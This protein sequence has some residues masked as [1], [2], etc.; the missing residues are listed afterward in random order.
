MILE[1]RT[2]S[3]FLIDVTVYS[4]GFIGDLFTLLTVQ[5]PEERHVNVVI[6]KHV[7][8]G[9]LLIHKIISW[10][11]RASVNSSAD[12]FFDARSTSGS[13]RVRGPSCR[14]LRSC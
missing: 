11:R 5:F 12:D 14:D 2:L 13:S 9:L 4:S 1:A 3:S 6:V 10:S 7:E 8:D